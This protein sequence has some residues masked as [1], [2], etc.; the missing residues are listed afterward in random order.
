[1]LV[2]RQDLTLGDCYL[3]QYCLVLLNSQTQPD[4]LFKTDTCTKIHVMFDGCS[5]W[6]YCQ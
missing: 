3:Q 2:T 1:M 4:V 6:S 5:R